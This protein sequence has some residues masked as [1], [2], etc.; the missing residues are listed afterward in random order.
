MTTK[1]TLAAYYYPGFHQ[2]PETD[3]IP[4]P[5][6]TEWDMLKQAKRHYEGH[7]QPRVPLWGYEDEVDPTV[8]A[9]KIDTAA[10]HGI[11]VFHVGWYWYRNK[12]FLHEALERGY[13]NAPN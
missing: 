4:Y 13:L 10:Q 6:W 9:G 5:R 2:T 1:V 11:S 3:F 8:M 7:Y 12:P